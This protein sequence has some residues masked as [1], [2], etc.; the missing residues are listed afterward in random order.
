MTKFK[1]T[2][3]CENNVF[4]NLGA[5]AEHGWAAYI[6]TESGNYLFDTGQGQGIIPNAQ[7]FKKQLSGIQG[8]V[9]SHHHS[10]HTG[11]LLQVLEANEHRSLPVYAHPDL[12]R[13]G[14]LTRSSYLYI[15]VPE[16]RERLEHAGAD[17]KWNTTFTEIAPNLYVTGEVPRVTD[18]EFGDEDI[19][20]KTADGY[21]KDDIIDDQSIIMKT[22]EGLFIVL[23]CSHAGIINII[24][25]AIHMTGETRVHTVIGGTHLWCVSKEQQDRTIEELQSF[26]IQRLG[27]SHCTGFAMATRLAQVFGDRFFSCNVGTV[28]EV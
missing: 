17:F 14:Y 8:I 11:G 25:H 13:E 10:D 15:G 7:H 3:L 2:V 28:V 5:I 9:L 22:E 23:G 21:I 4:G 24:K 19:V 12:F 1:V 6:E 27:V 26:D 18:Y 20:I 16:T